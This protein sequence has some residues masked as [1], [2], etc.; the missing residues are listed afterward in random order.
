MAWEDLKDI[1]HEEQSSYGT[2]VVMWFIIWIMTEILEREC[3]MEPQI[4]VADK[5][6]QLQ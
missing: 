6:S 5:I 1:E 2:I 3:G 4:F